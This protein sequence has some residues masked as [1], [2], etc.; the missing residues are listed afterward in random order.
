MNG[1]IH[2]KRIQPIHIY[3]RQKNVAIHKLGVFMKG[4]KSENKVI[5]FQHLRYH[6]KYPRQVRYDKSNV[7]NPLGECNNKETRNS[8]NNTQTHTNTL[9][10]Q[11]QLK[12]DHDLVE[13]LE[14][15]CSLLL[16]DNFL[17]RNCLCLCALNSLGFIY[18][19]IF[20]SSAYFG[21]YSQ[22]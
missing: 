22:T 8:N 16:G 10:C 4:T 13:M 6:N 18:Q 12:G 21:V 14:N 2:V 7:F 5:A 1:N 19:T 9:A 20:L 11:T 3:S 15:S 17:A